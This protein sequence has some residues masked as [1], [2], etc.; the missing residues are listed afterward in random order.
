M[1][2]TLLAAAAHGGERLRD[3]QRRTIPLQLADGTGSSRGRMTS[4]PMTS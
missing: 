1:L 2:I 3:W 4:Q